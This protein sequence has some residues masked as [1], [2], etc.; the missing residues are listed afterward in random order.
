MLSCPGKF[1]N[2]YGINPGIYAKYS[3]NLAL[4][5]IWLATLLVGCKIYGTK[6]LEKSE[7]KRPFV[8]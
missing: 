6:Q 7:S 3:G 1:W 4:F 8:G 5:Q 2:L